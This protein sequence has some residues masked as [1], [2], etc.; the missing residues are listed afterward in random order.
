[1]VLQKQSSE[2]VARPVMEVPALLDR[3]G[4]L[5]AWRR[6]TTAVASGGTRAYELDGYGKVVTNPL[7]S[8]RRQIVLTDAY[9][10][11]SEQMG[12]LAALSIAVVTPSFGIRVPDVVWMPCEK[13]EGLDREEPLPIVPDLCIEVL[14]DRGTVNDVDRR[15]G[16]YLEGGAA[17][18]I[19]VGPHGQTELHGA[20]GRRQASVFGVV[21]SL[22]PLYFDEPVV[23]AVHRGARR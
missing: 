20:E 12:H 5:A 15:V 2:F 19:V 10:Q 22:D 6:A 14:L 23:P 16:A 13:W 17:E 21:L 4:L 18:I 9:C 7:P 3:T 11:V 1:M 8:A